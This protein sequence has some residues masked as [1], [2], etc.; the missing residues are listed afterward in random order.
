LL[1]LRFHVLNDLVDFFVLVEANKTHTGHKKEFLFEKNKDKF[2][3]Y[4]NKIIYVQVRDLPDYKLPDIWVPENF[5]RNCIRRGLTKANVGDKIII[6]DIDEIP[7][8]HAIEWHLKDD[9][10]VTLTQ[11]LF[12]YYVNC[13]QRQTWWGS[14]LS[15]HGDYEEPQV[16]RNMARGGYNPMPNG[17]WHYSFMGGPEKI[18]IKVENIAESHLIID[19]VGDVD[20]IKTKMELQKDLW[21]RTDYFAQKRIVNIDI[22]GLA[23]DCIHWFINKYPDFF[24]KVQ[25]V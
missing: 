15:T 1:D 16:L 25:G 9:K 18:K 22:T 2:S 20:E 4:M 8:P 6:S 21:N 14:V 23:P 11:Y 12:Y 19:K 10:P 5:Q 13:M 24:F 7:N 3:D 17:G